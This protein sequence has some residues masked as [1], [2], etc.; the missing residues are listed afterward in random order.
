MRT[1]PILFG[2]DDKE[3]VDV[4]PVIT[5]KEVSNHLRICN[6]DIS[7]SFSC[8]P[9]VT[10]QKRCGRKKPGSTAVKHKSDKNSVDDNVIGDSLGNISGYDHF[11]EV[12]P[13][14]SGWVKPLGWVQSKPVDLTVSVQSDC[15][16]NNASLASRTNTQSEIESI[17]GA[18]GD[19][20]TAFM[21]RSIPLQSST[22]QYPISKKP[23]AQTPRPAVELN[24]YTQRVKGHRTRMLPSP[25]NTRTTNRCP[26]TS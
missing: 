12:S 23:R 22:G 25:T 15:G 9:V 26:G 7:A 16:G 14:G 5:K 19:V 11:G 8:R 13:V 1:K 3:N 21:V 10:Q 20:A 18:S 24:G 2:S 6:N 17:G 4:H